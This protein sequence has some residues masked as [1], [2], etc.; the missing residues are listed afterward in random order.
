M[1]IGFLAGGF[2]RSK[3][4]G[5]RAGFVFCY[6]GEGSF[7]FIAFSLEKIKGRIYENVRA[8]IMIDSGVYIGTDFE[9][10]VTQKYVITFRRNIPSDNLEARLFRKTDEGF[11]LYR[12]LSVRAFGNRAIQAACLLAY[13]LCLSG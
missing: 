13:R 8:Y 11:L 3:Y 7:D 12:N 10:A 6:D 1:W 4:A 2:R 5:R 9:M